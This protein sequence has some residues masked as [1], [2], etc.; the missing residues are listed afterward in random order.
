[1][2][3]FTVFDLPVVTE[4]EKRNY[5]H[6][7]KALLDDGFLMIQYSVY[8]RYCPSEEAAA[9]HRRRVKAHLPPEGE[10]RMLHVTDR[11]FAKMDVYVG[12]K[13]DSPEKPPEQLTLF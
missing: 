13:R 6:F 9:V 8:A 11:Q 2:W 4:E 7:R 12:R 5:T 10:V 1:V 3:I